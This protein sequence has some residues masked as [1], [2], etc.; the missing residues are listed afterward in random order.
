MATVTLHGDPIHTSGELPA[1][2]A[3]APDFRLIDTQL[4]E[5]SLADFHGRRKVLNIV[6]SLDTPVCAA[7]ARR[8]DQEA[9]RLHNV[10]VL[11]VSADLPFTQARIAK[12]EQIDNVTMLSM[13]RARDFADPWGIGLIEGPLQG[14]CARAVVVLDEDDRVLHSQLVPEISDEPDY[15]RALAVLRES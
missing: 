1:E 9:S 14:I 7:Q 10:E 15:D 13:V 6:G 5:R 8:F 11:V 3:Q 4:N 12:A 2:G